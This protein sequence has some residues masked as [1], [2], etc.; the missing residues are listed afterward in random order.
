MSVSLRDYQQEGVDKLKALFR[1]G[2][3]NLLYVLPTGGGKTRIFCNIAN[4]AQAK[5][6]NV[7]I[8]VHRTELLS[9]TSASLSELDVD[10]GC[11]APKLP[12]NGKKVQVASVQTLVNRM[13]KLNWT[14]DLIIIDEA[15]HLTRKSTWGKIVDF[16]R[17]ARAIGVTATPCRLDGQGLGIHNNGIFQDMVMGPQPRWLMDQGFLVE[18]EIYRPS[19]PLD[20]SKVP[21]L[22]GDYKKGA[23]GEFMDKP[24]I[25]G[26]AVDHY[27]KFSH[28]LPAIAFCASVKHA[29]HVA[30]EFRQ[31]GYVSVA[32]DG[33]TDKNLRKN[34]IS[35]LGKGKIHVLTSC[36]IISEGTDVPIV[37]T[38][39]GLRPTQS[40]SK[41]L[42][43]GGR[44][45]RPH[46][47]KKSAIIL[48]AVANY[49]IH[50]F[51]DDD[52]EWS[53]DAKKKSGRA[54]A[55]KEEFPVKECPAPGCYHVHKPAPMCPQCG[56]VYP[57]MERVI[58]QVDGDL[59]KIDVKKERES[60]K[61][62]VRKTRTLEDL[63]KL[64]KD[65]GY[66]DGWAEHV[67]ESR[68]RGN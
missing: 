14:P 20:L 52:R 21:M 36:D 19:V 4:S 40:L 48:D 12:F 49:K 45:L 66:K 28:N 56:Y 8:L 23:L 58:D 60:R 22:A 32:V 64:G 34:A 54:K 55:L 16:Y 18:P 37:T 31:A 11:I 47:D 25:T 13:Y 1:T 53:L 9:Q 15:H 59:E 62:V 2:L 27:R 50:G 68:K 17:R 63:I 42:Q 7:L 10:H 65:L 57:I 51:F 26:N 29:V 35:D 38:A 46:K 3:K 6:S 41:Y 67:H 33:N 5:G 43:M 30:E 24:S 61:T 44:V 39:I